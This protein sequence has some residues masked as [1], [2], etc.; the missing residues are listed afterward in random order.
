MSM[1]DKA[2][3]VCSLLADY[4]LDYDQLELE[5]DVENQQS[6]LDSIGEESI[7]PVSQHRVWHSM[8]GNRYVVEDVVTKDSDG[9][10]RIR[11]IL[12]ALIDSPEGTTA[13][14]FLQRQPEVDASAPEGSS[15]ML[16]VYSPSVLLGYCHY[17]GRALDVNAV[18]SVVGSAVGPQMTYWIDDAGEHVCLQCQ[19]GYL[20]GSVRMD[21][22]MVLTFTAFMPETRVSMPRTLWPA[23]VVP[24]ADLVGRV[25][26]PK[27]MQGKV[28]RAD[29]NETLEAILAF[30]RPFASLKTRRVKRSWENLWVWLL[31][32]QPV[33]NYVAKPLGGK[34][35]NANSIAHILSLMN[36]EGVVELGVKS[37]IAKLQPEANENFRT[38]LSS[39]P[40]DR[41]RGV[42]RG[43][44]EKVVK[45]RL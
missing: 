5:F 42:V 4:E 7:F 6:I 44:L 39:P 15:A 37:H 45:S 11:H 36:E 30:V 29:K 34:P 33:W 32:F 31:D 21:G 16:L 12:H 27:G 23:E 13:C 43:Y 26:S 14:S 1:I 19:G 24:F 40:S 3:D 35:F 22:P 38:N 2:L 10:Y 20:L 28:L 8:L 9:N 17:C 25:M 41:V 18:A